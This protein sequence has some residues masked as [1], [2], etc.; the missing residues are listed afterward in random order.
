MHKHNLLGKSQI[1]LKEVSHLKLGFS[2]AV[3]KHMHKDMI[4]VTMG[5]LNR[6]FN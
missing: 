5:V 4:Q 2:E 6:F 3:N 1:L